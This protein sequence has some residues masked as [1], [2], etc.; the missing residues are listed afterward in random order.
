[1]TRVRL[2]ALLVASSLIA[3]GC[4]GPS[5]PLHDSPT[6]AGLTIAAWNM[7]H[8][9]AA[10]G[11]GCRP[12]DDADYAAMRA[13]A[14]AVDA[15]VI[16]FQEVESEAAAYR[17]FDPATWVVVIEDRAGSADRPE[18]RG[19][20]GL[21][22]NAQRTGFAIRRDL[23]FERLP[24]LTTLQLGDPD[25][26]SGVDIRVTPRN[27]APLRLLS[28]HLKSGCSTGADR[29]ACPV[30]FDQAP[31]LEAWIDD[32]ARE[33]DRFALLGDFNR[34]LARPGD[35]VWSGWDDADP[36]NADL[37]LASDDRGARCDPRYADFIDFIVLDRR[38]GAQLRDFHEHRFQT[39]PLSDHCA[40]SAR[41]AP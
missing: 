4:T 28:V 5:A 15:D 29:D 8:L 19:R 3:G 13:Y 35:M 11:T 25:L 24:D 17:V 2:A 12:R 7:E 40:L 21:T 26:R 41:L 10:N 18:C 34:R 22:L 27:G 32:R 14:E 23:P 20:P 38:A 36:A 33:D 16:A 30:L 37:R 31:V 6:S 39:E 9:A 1:M